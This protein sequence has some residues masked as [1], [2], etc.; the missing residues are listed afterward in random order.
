M[1]RTS[2]NA[3]IL[4][5]V[6]GLSGLFW[7]CD[8]PKKSQGIA[9]EPAPSDS[10]P[11]VIRFSDPGNAGVFAYA[12]REGILARELAKVDATIEWVPGGG[13]FSATA[14]AM[15]S[16]A[17]NASGGAVSPIV[18]ALSH[19]LPFRIYAVSDPGGTRRAGIVSPASSSIR[20]VQDL[21][22]KRVAVNL[23]AH[24]DYILLKAL[25][26]AG[27]PAGSVTRVPIQPPDAAAAFASGKIDAWSTFGVY[28]STA[29][30]NGAHVVATEDEIQSD[31]VGVLSANAAV[32]E[33]GP[34]AFQV[35]LKVSQELTEI[36]HQSPEKFENV[37]T[38]K[39]PTALS[40]EELRTATE[41]TRTLPAFRIPNA[42]DRIRIANVARL[43]F[44]NHSIDR[45]ISVAEI[46][47]D[48]DEAAKRA[49][50]N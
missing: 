7:A 5:V 36:A 49:S 37:F 31:D 26:H 38:E 44:D 2:L 42:A 30:R 12:K 23:A 41:E 10:P 3:N 4:A 40:G 34:R 11:I 28:F 25:S 19:K 14:D 27:V 22:G 50:A 39:G 21:V 47:F 33:K 16:G 8:S 48:I 1:S 15:N 9:P 35:I 45:D 29:V 18:G 24:G 32:L 46:V 6:V 17:I 43:L 13:S 20:T